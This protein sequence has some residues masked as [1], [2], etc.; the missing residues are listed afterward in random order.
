MSVKI[1]LGFSNWWIHSNICEYAE[2]FEKVSKNGRSKVEKI[3]IIKL[4]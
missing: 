3:D 2:Y 1:I 4:I